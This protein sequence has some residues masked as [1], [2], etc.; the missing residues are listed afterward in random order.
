MRDF[1]LFY[2]IIYRLSPALSPTLDNTGLQAPHRQRTPN[3]EVSVSIRC[4]NS[5]LE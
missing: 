2:H 5:L 3:D 1:F 4:R